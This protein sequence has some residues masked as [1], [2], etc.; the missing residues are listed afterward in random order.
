MLTREEFEKVDMRVGTVIDVQDFPEAKNP[1]Y[2]IWIDFGDE[3]GIKKTSAQ[4]TKLYKK[5]DILGKQ[6]VAVVNFPPKQ[7]ASFMS[8]C[9]ILGAINGK[10]ITLLQPNLPC[11]NGLRIG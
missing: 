1:A 7:I 10:D 5:E 11:D 4:V 9:L 3:V 8:E 2:Q 6:V